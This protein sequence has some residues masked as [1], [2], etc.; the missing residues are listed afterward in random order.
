MSSW[1]ACVRD[2]VFL[3]LCVRRLRTRQLDALRSSH[4]IEV[5]VQSPSQIN[6][7]FD[8]ISYSKGARNKRVWVGG[9]WVEGGGS[10]QL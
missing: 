10:C 3:W 1:T 8:A 2:G 9:P 4:P 5:D 7:I 6:Q